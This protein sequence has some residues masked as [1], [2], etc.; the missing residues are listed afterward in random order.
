MLV[1]PKTT[2]NPNTKKHTY[3]QRKTTYLFCLSALVSLK[4]R[5]RLDPSSRPCGP[6]SSSPRNAA[7][8]ISVVCRCSFE[9]GCL[10]R[11]T[12]VRHPT[13]FL[14]CS[15]TGEEMKN[16]ARLD[17]PIVST[18]APVVATMSRL[19]LYPG[20]PTSGGRTFP[21]D[22]FEHAGTQSAR[23]RR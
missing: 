23:L 2:C 20:R 22:G 9:R 5:R 18:Q 1:L 21:I 10:H 19:H 16:S 17:V 14:L 11:E 15:R 7:T 12:A 4:A 13:F 6:I 3:K 8:R